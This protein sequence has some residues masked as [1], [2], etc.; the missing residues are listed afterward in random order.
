I[1]RYDA[2]SGD[3]VKKTPVG[4]SPKGIKIDRDGRYAF[5]ADDGSDSPSVIEVGPTPHN[6]VLSSGN[7]RLYVILHG[8]IGVAVVDMERL[9]KAG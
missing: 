9:E 7:E 2:A 8:G 1:Y 3:L 6:S 4:D 5:A